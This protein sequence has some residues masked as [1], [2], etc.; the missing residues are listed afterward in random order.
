MFS[1]WSLLLCHGTKHYV[2]KDLSS[3]KIITIDTREINKPDM[4][5]NIYEIK[6][7]KCPLF[8]RVYFMFCP[9]FKLEDYIKVLNDVVK[10]VLKPGGS[11][12]TP[13]PWLAKI[14]G[15]NESCP[16]LSTHELIVEYMKTHNFI[17]PKP[18]ET[19]NVYSPT[20]YIFKYRKNIK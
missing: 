13:M 15:R 17:N 14:V 4:I 11:F 5:L 3:N 7:H 2:P 12:I 10:K 18:Y 9:V 8:D 6:C 20:M 1:G 19:G 16:S